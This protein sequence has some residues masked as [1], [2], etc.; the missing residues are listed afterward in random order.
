MFFP[1]GELAVCVL[2][3]LLQC[4]VTALQGQLESARTAGLMVRLHIST[5]ST[6]FGEPKHLQVAISGHEG[7]FI[8]PWP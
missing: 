6:P 3:P 2:D 4:V 7:P 8:L 1:D 5:D